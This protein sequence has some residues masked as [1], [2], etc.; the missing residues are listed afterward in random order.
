MQ[1][2]SYPPQTGPGFEVL[3][4]TVQYEYPSGWHTAPTS[5]SLSMYPRPAATANLSNSSSLGFVTVSSST[6]IADSAGRHS[7]SSSS[8]PSMTT[9]ATL[10][11]PRR[12]AISDAGT[13]TTR[14]W[15]TLKP[16]GSLVWL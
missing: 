13:H 2:S 16:S 14:A 9:L 8:A 6:P 10:A 7:V 5:T 3:L 15:L 4:T 1:P 12:S 11:E